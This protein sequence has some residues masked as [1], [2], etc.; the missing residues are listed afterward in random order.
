MRR[1]HV[2]DNLAKTLSPAAEAFRYFILE[3]GEAYLAQHFSH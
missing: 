3:R 1:L 2:V